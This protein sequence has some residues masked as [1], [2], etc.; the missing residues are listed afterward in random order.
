MHNN[1]GLTRI[2][3]ELLLL[4]AETNF[5]VRLRNSYNIKLF[6]VSSAKRKQ[7]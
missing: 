1:M 7:H 5:I 3:S 6:F 4:S 2:Q